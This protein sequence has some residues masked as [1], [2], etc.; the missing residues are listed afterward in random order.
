MNEPL[1]LL[2][3]VSG[4][5]FSVKLWLIA[6]IS[7]THMCAAQVMARFSVLCLVLWWHSSTFIVLGRQ[8]FVAGPEL[9]LFHTILCSTR[10]TK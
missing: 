3:S 1:A 5:C 8:E 6:H 10:V 4:V 9:S 7:L 2:L